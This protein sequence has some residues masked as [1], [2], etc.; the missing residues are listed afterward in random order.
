MQSLVYLRLGFGRKMFQA[1]L[2]DDE[3]VG[4]EKVVAGSDLRSI[5]SHV[6][7]VRQCRAALET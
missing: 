7:R 3:H 4:G 2:K 1:S 5:S 6:V